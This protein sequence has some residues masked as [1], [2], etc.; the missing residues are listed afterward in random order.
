LTDTAQLLFQIIPLSWAA[1][2]SPTALSLF[3]V[4]MTLTDNPKLAGLSF[5]F[6]AI[7]VL[8]ITVII[9]IVLG[10]GLSMTGHTSPATI[11]AVDLFLGA[12]LI[13]L[14]IRSLFGRGKEGNGALMKYLDIDNNASNLSKFKRYFT[15]G[16]LTFLINFS[17][18][19]F[20]L[21]AGR[22]IGLADA[23]L[24]SNLIS[25][26]VLAIITLVV[27][28]VPLL[29]FFVFPETAE[30]TMKPMKTWIHNNGNYLIAGFLIIIG[31]YVV[32]NGLGRLGMT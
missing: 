31:I 18:A 32:Y 10:N 13:L 12:I 27:I 2:V 25:I 24:I 8:L 23:G 30:K 4:M 21:A 5:Y 3:L 26:V 29:F 22:Q 28:E 6:G 14:G 17:T 9:G 19:I 16:L 20:V 1:A 15:V 7:I 11:A